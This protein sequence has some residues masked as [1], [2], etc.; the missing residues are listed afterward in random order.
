MLVPTPNKINALFYLFTPIWPQFLGLEA[1]ERSPL[2]QLVMHED[3]PPLRL[4][5]LK[6]FYTRSWDT[7]PTLAFVVSSSQLSAGLLSLNK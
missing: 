6:R 2:L 1:Q 7:P 3:K 5:N 4:A